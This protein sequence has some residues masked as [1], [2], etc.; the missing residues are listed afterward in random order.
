MTR[1]VAMGDVRELFD[2]NPGE[3]QRID[4]LVDHSRIAFQ[5]AGQVVAA[6]PGV[7]TSKRT[8]GK[9]RAFYHGYNHADAEHFQTD[10]EER[11]HEEDDDAT[12]FLGS[13]QTPDFCMWDIAEPFRC[14]RS[15]ILFGLLHEPPCQYDLTSAL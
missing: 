12:A 11:Q 8:V 7:D 10:S 4:Q 14:L 15:L 3:L 5:N 13:Q 2:S 1:G 6:I 9:Q